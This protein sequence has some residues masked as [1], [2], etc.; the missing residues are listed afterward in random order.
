MVFILASDLDAF[1][2]YFHCLKKLTQQTQPLHTMKVNKYP[3]KTLLQ[4]L[5]SIK[6]KVF[7]WLLAYNYRTLF[8]IDASVYRIALLNSGLRSTQKAKLK[9]R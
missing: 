8:C 1:E 6:E 2:K 3:G 9:R 5:V 4:D 7:V